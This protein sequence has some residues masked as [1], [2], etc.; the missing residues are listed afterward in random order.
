MNTLG[1]DIGGTKIYVARY[2]EKLE[3]EAETR[4][5]TKANK[6]RKHT[7]ANLLKAINEVRN[8]ETVGLGVAWAGFVDVDAG[9]I[10]KAPN[11]PHLDGFRLCDYLAEQT[12]LKAIIENDARAFAFGAKSK[13]APNSKLCLGIIIGT[14][15]G[16]GI[17]YRNQ[18]FYGANG[19]AG[20]IG[21]MV[22]QQKEVEA[23]LAGPG[24]KK[25][26]G[27]PQNTNFS[28]ILPEKQT[29]L[30]PQIEQALSVFAQWLSG[31][32]MS[33]NPD[34]ILI[35]GGTGIHFWQHFKKE[36]I[37]RTKAQLKSYP[38]DFV[39]DFYNDNNAGAAGAAALSK[40]N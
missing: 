8:H 40:L 24:L 29:A 2:N 1:I 11:V 33:F 37:S 22:I 3:I 18:I 5:P 21:H 19:F 39:I 23:W 17:I 13:A 30:L 4:V 34:T 9:Q 25:E 26:L 28:D 36:I 16:G 31:L 15:V 27:L 35:G 6:T 14:G 12:G 7:L 38:Q 20:E 32:V 10:V